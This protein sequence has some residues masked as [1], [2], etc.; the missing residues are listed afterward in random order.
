MEETK[1]QDAGKDLSN[2][3]AAEVGGG[4]T[5]GATATV[6]STTSVTNSAPTVG[7][8][9]NG[10]YDGVVEATTHVIETVAHSIK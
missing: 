1:K 4:A 5:C 2:E 8:A 3:Q 7:E 9:L 6:G 10:I